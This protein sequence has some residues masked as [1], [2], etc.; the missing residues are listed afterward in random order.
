MFPVT[1]Q[2]SQVLND[3]LLRVLGWNPKARL[4]APVFKH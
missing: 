2:T 1:S 3:T 4:A